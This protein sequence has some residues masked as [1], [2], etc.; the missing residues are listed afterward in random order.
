MYQF[1]IYYKKCFYSCKTCNL[2]GN[3]LIHN[4]IECNDNF[5]LG[6]KKNDYFNCY[7][8]CRNYYYFDKKNNFICTAN[9]SC[10]K[11]FP[12]LSQ[13][14]KECIKYNIQDIINEILNN[15]RDEIEKSK[16]KKYIFMIIFYKS[17]K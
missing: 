1:R 8:N 15:E 4:C 11:E 16:E 5:Q 3:D 2:G 6:I 13:N 17:L 7:E 10:P 14:K 9:L 12:R